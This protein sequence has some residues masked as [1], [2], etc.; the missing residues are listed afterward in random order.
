MECKEFEEKLPLFLD[1]RYSEIGNIEEFED[2]FASCEECWREYAESFALLQ[3]M[4]RCKDLSE[5]MPPAYEQFHESVHSAMDEGLRGQELLR[6]IEKGYV[7]SKEGTP[8]YEVAKLV[9]DTKGLDLEKETERIVENILR[10]EELDPDNPKIFNFK[11]EVVDHLKVKAYDYMHCYPADHEAALPVIKMLRKL[12]P[13]FFMAAVWLASASQRVGKLEESR[14]VLDEIWDKGVDYYFETDNTLIHILGR[15][16][17]LDFGDRPDD[18]DRSYYYLEMAFER[19]PSNIW[20]AMNLAWYYFCD[21]EY[22]KSLIVVNKLFSLDI[23]KDDLEYAADYISDMCR[24][25]LNEKR[26][27]AYPCIIG[28]LELAHNKF[29]SDDFIMYELMLMHTKSGQYDEALGYL[30][31]LE[32]FNYKDFH[33][34]FLAAEIYCAKRNKKKAYE[35]ANK[36]IDEALDR[37]PDVER[38]IRRLFETTGIDD[39]D[40]KAEGFEDYILTDKEIPGWMI[41][42]LDEERECYANID[43]HGRE[44]FKSKLN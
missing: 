13:T 23:D 43:E 26:H 38:V 41:P 5:E 31:K 11:W 18:N 19:N 22:G 35:Y 27:E 44:V 30:K 8:E 37:K 40:E 2:H 24:I 16:Y 10:I 28:M 39:V 12:N 17:R 42:K 3:T 1:E 21:K 36:T 4:R 15:I 14:K 6:A 20:P 29:P 32:N 33:T 34:F 25:A 7:A 9:Y